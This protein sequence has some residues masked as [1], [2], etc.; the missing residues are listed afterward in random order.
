[1]SKGFVKQMPGV[2]C[3]N[4]LQIVTERPIPRLRE[5]TEQNKKQELF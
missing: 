2:A 5:L 4:I 3:L 1:M